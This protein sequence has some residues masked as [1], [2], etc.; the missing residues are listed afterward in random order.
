MNSSTYIQFPMKQFK[1]VIM[2]A[3][4]I[5]F[6]LVM[7]EYFDTLGDFM[8]CTLERLRI[9]WHLKQSITEAFYV[10]KLPKEALKKGID[11][12]FLL[13]DTMNPILKKF[14]DDLK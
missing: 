4:S 12:T 8:D 1:G 9:N 14:I 2:N 10:L 5:V 11:K 6:P 7:D 3:P 13:T